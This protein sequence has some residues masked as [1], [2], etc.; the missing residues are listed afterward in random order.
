[1]SSYDTKAI[2]YRP[3]DGFA[4]RMI[5]TRMDPEGNDVLDKSGFRGDPYI[6]CALTEGG[7]RRTTTDVYQFC[8]YFA[9]GGVLFDLLNICKMDKSIW[10]E[11]EDGGSYEVEEL[12]EIA[13]VG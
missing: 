3:S 2:E 6:I 1:M 13:D 5:L 4:Y 12:E 11:L 9:D 7:I 8:T 10:A